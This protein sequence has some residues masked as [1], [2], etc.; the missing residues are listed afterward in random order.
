MANFN[1]NTQR[2][3]DFSKKESQFSSVNK[4]NGYLADEVNKFNTD[5]ARIKLMFADFNAAIQDEKQQL[6][7][8]NILGAYLQKLDL[9]TSMVQNDIIKLSTQV[10]NKM[11]PLSSNDNT[12][13]A[14]QLVIANAISIFNLSLNDGNIRTA[15]VYNMDKY[16]ATSQFD[17]YSTLLELELKKNEL[18][19]IQ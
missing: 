14:S 12:M 8:Q 4:Y 13:F 7:Y 2:M 18:V 11:Y 9:F 17:F 3:S 10:R 15:F 5:G 16:I 19:H 6:Q 1:F